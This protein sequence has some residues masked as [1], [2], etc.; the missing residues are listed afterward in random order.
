M[1][2]FVISV[3]VFALVIAVMAIGVIFGRSP[4]KG[5]CGGMGAMGMTGPCE[6]CGGDTQRC[7]QQS[8]DTGAAA[9]N[10]GLYRPADK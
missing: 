6:I 10:P 9:R 1:A 5:S 4:I 7:E 8:G 2:E 3:F